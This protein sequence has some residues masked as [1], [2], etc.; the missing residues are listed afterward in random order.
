[1]HAGEIRAEREGHAVL[2]LSSFHYP[3]VE[4]FIISQ[5][6]AKAP[7]YLKYERYFLK[8]IL[9][10][11]SSLAQ[12][13]LEVAVRSSDSIKII[14]VLM[15]RLSPEDQ[16]RISL[17]LP[18]LQGGPDTLRDLIRINYLLVELH[19][20]CPP[21]YSAYLQKLIDVALATTNEL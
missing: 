10:N 8:Y 16:K 13:L 18:Y 3:S 21:E 15:Q 5:I 1:M 7:I 19:H 4:K 9:S 20:E 14:F 6:E 11:W 12:P 17:A 2:F